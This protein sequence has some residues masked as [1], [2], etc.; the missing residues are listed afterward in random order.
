ML[1]QVNNLLA[2]FETGLNLDITPVLKTKETWDA[3]GGNANKYANDRSRSSTCFNR[4][5]TCWQ[6]SRLGSISIS[7]PCSK[8]KK[9]GMLP[10]ATRT[11]MRTTVPLARSFKS[12]RGNTMKASWDI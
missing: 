1:Q 10:E 4:S 5:T 12:S 7:P 2:I 8:P 11:N 9:H 6:S 3:S